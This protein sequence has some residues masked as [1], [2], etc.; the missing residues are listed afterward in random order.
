MDEKFWEKVRTGPGCWEWQGSTDGHGY[1]QINRARGRSPIKAHRFSWVAENG[2]IP[3]GQWVLHKCD[4]PPC[5]RPSHLYLGDRSR[6]TKDAIERGRYLTPFMGQ[7]NPAAKLTAFDVHM[8][9]KRAYRG[10]QPIDIARDYPVSRTT[11]AEIVARKSW[12]H[13]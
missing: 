8:I 11:V 2:E 3:Q 4:N 5:V 9:R 7:N 1:G 12:R 13:V 10:E 6:N